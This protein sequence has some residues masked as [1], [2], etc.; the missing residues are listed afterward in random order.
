[1]YPFDRDYLA[2]DRRRPLSRTDCQIVFLMGSVVQGE[3]VVLPL[4]CDKKFPFPYL[5]LHILQKDEVFIFN[6]CLKCLAPL[7]GEQ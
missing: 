5:C 1:M 3:S 2:M 6:Q 7:T 4:A